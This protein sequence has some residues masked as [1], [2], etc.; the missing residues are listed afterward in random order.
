MS[1]RDTRMPED[2]RPNDVPWPAAR[3]EG[4]DGLVLARGDV[5]LRAFRANDAAALFSALDHDA[6]WAHVVGRPKSAEDFANV[7]NDAS[8]NGRHVFVVERD[9]RGSARR[10]PRDL[11]RLQCRDRLLAA[12]GRGR[13][14]V[15]AQH[16][17]DLI[18]HFPDRVQRRARV[19]ENHRDFAAAQVAPARAITKVTADLGFVQT[20]GN[21]QLTTLNVGER[22]TQQRNRLSL[23]QQLVIVYSEQRDTVKASQLRVITRG[24]YRIDQILSLFVGVTFDRNA[25]AGIRRRFDEQVGIQ[26]RLF[27]GQRDTLYYEALIQWGALLTG[28]GKYEEAVRQFQ[29]AALVARRL[30][31][32]LGPALVCLVWGLGPR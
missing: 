4:V 25:F 5:R 24:D 16:V 28:Q 20:G 22:F 30:G 10:L 11:H 31:D 12:I 23:L 9:D 27:A 14:H 3:W 17:L 7:L 13:L 26:A 18:T 29:T 19:L 8:A 2:S 6:C 21:T 1:T 32:G 15:L